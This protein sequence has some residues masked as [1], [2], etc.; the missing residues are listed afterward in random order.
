M[1][2]LAVERLAKGWAFEQIHGRCRRDGIPKDM[3]KSCTFDNGKEFAFFKQLGQ[4]WP[5]AHIRRDLRL[6]PALQTELKT[7][8]LPTNHKKVLA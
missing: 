6:K 4:A 7:A 3:L 1:W 8:I 5:S 2:S